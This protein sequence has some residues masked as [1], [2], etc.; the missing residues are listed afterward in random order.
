M[1]AE[2]DLIVS[3]IESAIA[4][5]HTNPN[6]AERILTVAHE[7]LIELAEQK[8]PTILLPACVG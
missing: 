5:L 6:T 4:M 1:Q 8:P 2:L 7:R 3:E